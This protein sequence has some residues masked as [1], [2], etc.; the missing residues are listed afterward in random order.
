L[1]APFSPE[2]NQKDINTELE[3][4][5][6]VVL[7]IK[8]LQ[9]RVGP[10]M[11]SSMRGVGRGEQYKTDESRQCLCGSRTHLSE[12]LSL[13]RFWWLSSWGHSEVR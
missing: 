12:E 11:A 3:G 13:S 1:Q 9:A 2:A 10:R 8:P 7:L 6:R 4:A 5:Q